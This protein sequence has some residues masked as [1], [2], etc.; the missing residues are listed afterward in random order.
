MSRYYNPDLKQIH[1]EAELRALHPNTLFPRPFSPPDGWFPL[2][3]QTPP[4]YDKVKQ[5]LVDQLPVLLPSGEYRESFAVVSL[6][7]TTQA[8]N[9]KIAQENFVASLENDLSRITGLQSADHSLTYQDAKAYVDLDYLGNPPP[10][11]LVFASVHGLHPVD[12]ANEI[13]ARNDR[14]QTLIKLMSEARIRAAALAATSISEAATFWRQVMQFAPTSVPTQESIDALREF[15]G[16]PP[17]AEE[18]SRYS[19]DKLR[20]R[21]RALAVPGLI[22]GMGADNVQRVRNGEWTI[23]D[24]HELNSN[25]ITTK[26]IN[27]VLLYSFEL[28]IQALLEA[29]HPLLTPEVKGKWVNDLQAHLY[30]D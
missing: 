3:K 23:E 30:L 26:V 9:Q 28:A 10:T 11:V 27:L 4:P 19:K 20:L 8:K 7:P 22:S 29:D 25:P 21:K 17:P 5:K 18:L 12:A 24:L 1:T 13:V 14:W 2:V 16:E 6:P 15:L